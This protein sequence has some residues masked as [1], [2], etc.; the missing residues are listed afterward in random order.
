VIC[1]SV[2][3][4]TGAPLTYSVYESASGLA[5]HAKVTVRS[6]S[7]GRVSAKSKVK[8]FMVIQQRLRLCPR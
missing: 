7:D 8:V 3:L 1:V 4:A 5:S 2:V 6:A